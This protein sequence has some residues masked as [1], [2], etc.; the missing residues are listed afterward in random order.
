M[1]WPVDRPRI[2]PHGGYNFHRT[3]GQFCNA[4]PPCDHHGVD[5]GGAGGT[6]V[7]AP[8]SGVLVYTFAGDAVKPFSR[9]GPAG[10][11]LHGAESG[12][13]HLLMHLEA[14][15]VFT[16][17]QKNGRAT[18]LPGTIA[19]LEGQQ[20]GT[21]SRARKHLHWEVRAKPEDRGS[22][23]DPL[24]ILRQLGDASLVDRTPATSPAP[25]KRSGGGGWIVAI[26]V[27]LALHERASK[28]DR[29]L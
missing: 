27:V 20:I 6:P 19:V 22:H 7:Y 25:A 4:K 21:I 11:V 28:G 3:T 29:W 13:Y 12:L 5:L 16:A 26:L 24:G 18:R 17:Q 10:V 2:T 23:V 1:R 15:T 8:E 9:F 14:P